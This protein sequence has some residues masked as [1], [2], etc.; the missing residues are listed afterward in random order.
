MGHQK[1]QVYVDLCPSTYQDQS[2]SQK[3]CLAIDAFAGQA[4]VI[5]NSRLTQILWMC[6]YCSL[7]LLRKSPP[8]PREGAVLQRKPLGVSVAN[9]SITQ[10]G[11]TQ[12]YPC[13]KRMPYCRAEAAASGRVGRQRVRVLAGA[14]VSPQQYRDIQIVVGRAI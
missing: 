7:Q 13:P 10:S 4:Y 14:V 11:V 1:E 5:I 8:Y 2:G 12:S 9:R 6:W 3:S